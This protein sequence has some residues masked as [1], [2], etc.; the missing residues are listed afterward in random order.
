MLRPDGGAGW[1]GLRPRGDLLGTT[2]GLAKAVYVRES[3]RIKAAFTVAE[4]HVGTD[5]RMEATGLSREA[6]TAARFDD[7]VGKIV[8]AEGSA[9]S[10]LI[11]DAF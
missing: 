3:R 7:S 8:A 4:Q 10:S 2:D 5:A 9:A 1:R 6:V 11:S